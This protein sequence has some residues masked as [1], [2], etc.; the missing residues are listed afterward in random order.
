MVRHSTRSF[1][2]IL[3]GGEEIRGILIE[4]TSEVLRGYFGKDIT[5]LGKAI[6]RPSGTLLRV[7]ASEI[8]PV[9]EGGVASFFGSWPGEETDRELLQALE[10]V[11]SCVRA[12][13]SIR[14]FCLHSFAARLSGYIRSF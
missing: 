4:G 9:V 2:L 6:Y 10:E 11:R 3:D 13:C 14:A 5:V 1:G 8:L 7:D 12:V